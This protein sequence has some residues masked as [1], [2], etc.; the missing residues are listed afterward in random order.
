MRRMAL[1]LPLLLALPLAL[2][3]APRGTEQKPDPKSAPALPSF[4]QRVQPAVVGIKVQ[5]PRNR[6]S[7]LSLCG[8]YPIR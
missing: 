5:V 4:V 1:A 6:P 3:A 2:G 7:V 8:T